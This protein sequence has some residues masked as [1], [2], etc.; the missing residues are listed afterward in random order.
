MFFNFIKFPQISVHWDFVARTSIQRSA[1]RYCD[2]FLRRQFAAIGKI[3]ILQPISRYTDQTLFSK[4]TPASDIWWFF[5]LLLISKNAFLHNWEFLDK[6]L[7]FENTQITTERQEIQ[8][9]Y[10]KK[11]LGIYILWHHRIRIVW[12]IYHETLFQKLNLTQNHGKAI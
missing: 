3:C 4:F 10:L 5:T 8:T 7:I 1:K 2:D 6:N 12:F 9:I 11:D